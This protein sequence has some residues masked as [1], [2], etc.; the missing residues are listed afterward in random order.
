MKA[1]TDGLLDSRYLLNLS[2]MG[3]EMTRQMRLEAD[4]FDLD[5]FMHKVSH[6]IRKRTN[7]S[8]NKMDTDSINCWDW[9]KLGKIAARHSRRAPVPEHLLGPL[10]V[11]PRHRKATRSSRL[12]TDAVQVAPEQIDAAEMPQS[13]N[14]TSRLVLDIMQRLEACSGEEGVNL[15]QFALNPESFGD[16]VE[17]LFYI[18]FLIRDG[19]AAIVEN[20]EGDPMLLLS[21]VPTEEDRRAG[22]TRRQIVFELDMATW[23]DLIE[24]YDIQSA[25]IPTRSQLTASIPQ[26]G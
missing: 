18:S 1:P 14:E 16:S 7:L 15:F 25:M 22:L 26:S 24:V 3:A 21:E 10:Q 12:D 9:T 13:E 19:T 5:E 6:I 8:E 23:R 2:D 20:D 4:A 11:T 17:N